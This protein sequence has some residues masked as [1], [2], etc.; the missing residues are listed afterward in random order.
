MEKNLFLRIIDKRI[1]QFSMLLHSHMKKMLSIPIIVLQN[2]TVHTVPEKSEIPHKNRAH[3]G[4]AYTHSW[5]QLTY[6]L[7]SA[8]R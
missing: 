2:Y 4:W 3:Q 5:A 8:N 1:V 7:A 6:N